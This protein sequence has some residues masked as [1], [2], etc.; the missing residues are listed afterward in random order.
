MARAIRTCANCGAYQE[1]ADEERMGTCRRNAPVL[2]DGGPG[3]FP[4]VPPHW[5][6]AQWI[7]QRRLAAV[8]TKEEA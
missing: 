4:E 6:C 1:P 2:C 3:Q 7:S 5:W 8:D